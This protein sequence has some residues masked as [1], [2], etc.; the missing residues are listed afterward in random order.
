MASPLDQ[1]SN[2]YQPEILGMDRQRKL[3]EMLIAQGQQQPQAQMVGGRFIPVAPTQ[4]L[5]NL[6]NTALGTY[7]MYKAD[8]K[9]MD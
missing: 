7:G 5:A 8:E 4:N 3:A 2:P 9:A 1:Y 6:L